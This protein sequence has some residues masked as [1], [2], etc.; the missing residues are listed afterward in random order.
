[1]FLRRKRPTVGRRKRRER[2]LEEMAQWRAQTVRKRRART[3]N[4]SSH[5]ERR[6]RVNSEWRPAYS[7]TLTS[8]HTS[9]YVI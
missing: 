2:G 4:V 5:L 3:L 1:V 7:F 6:R 9:L 8:N